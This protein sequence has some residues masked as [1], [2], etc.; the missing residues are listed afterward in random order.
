MERKVN[1]TRRAGSRSINATS[2][3]WLSIA[4]VSSRLNQIL[5]MPLGAWRDINGL[6]REL[7]KEPAQRWRG[8]ARSRRARGGTHWYLC[9]GRITALE[10]IR[11]GRRAGR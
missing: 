2:R 11:E 1:N 4:I 5:Q 8:G 10:N 3:T 9:L 6:G 7:G